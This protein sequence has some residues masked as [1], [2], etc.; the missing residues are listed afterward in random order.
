MDGTYLGSPVHYYLKSIAENPKYADHKAFRA[1]LPD[2]KREKH[3]L[4]KRNF[5][6]PSK[7]LRLFDFDSTGGSEYA[8]AC[9]VKKNSISL[10]TSTP[11]LYFITDTYNINKALDPI[12]AEGYIAARFVFRWGYS[13]STLVALAE[14]PAVAFASPEQNV[15]ELYLQMRKFYKPSKF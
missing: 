5:T 2:F 14:E 1:L 13:L 12:P 15:E 7:F 4:F 8:F 6:H 11:L 9:L 3:S 10:G